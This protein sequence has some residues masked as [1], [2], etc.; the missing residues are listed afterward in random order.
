MKKLYKKFLIWVRKFLYK[1][2]R[3]QKPK[4]SHKPYEYKYNKNFVLDL[5]EIAKS[6]KNKMSIFSSPLTPELTIAS[7]QLVDDFLQKAQFENV[8][9][10]G[11]KNLV[12]G[13][14]NVIPSNVDKFLVDSYNKKIKNNKKLTWVET[15]KYIQLSYRL[16]AA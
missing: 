8:D 3:K 12:L 13:E 14:K 2:Y 11:L 9:Y 6:E 4:L 5:L 10:T 1:Y 16:K 15:K 7:N